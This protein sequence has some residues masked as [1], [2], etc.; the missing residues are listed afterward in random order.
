MFFIEQ[1]DVLEEVDDSFELSNT[2]TQSYTLPK[3]AIRQSKAKV[4]SDFVNF[5]ESEQDEDISEAS[6]WNV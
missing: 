5:S 6:E 2:L 4:Y 3:A 1:L